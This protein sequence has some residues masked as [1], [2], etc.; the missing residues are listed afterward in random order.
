MKWH[1]WRYRLYRWILLLIIF[2]NSFFFTFVIYFVRFFSAI[3]FHFELTH[4]PIRCQ[5]PNV[6]QKELFGLA[7]YSCLRSKTVCPLFFM[8]KSDEVISAMMSKRQKVL[9]KSSKECWMNK[10]AGQIG[11]QR[12]DCDNGTNGKK[13]SRFEEI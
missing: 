3:L 5:F 11:L 7:K 4:L 9:M 13:L 6:N 8:S 10:T 1:F 12:F 2:Q